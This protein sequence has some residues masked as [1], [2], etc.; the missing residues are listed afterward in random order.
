M[1]DQNSFAEFN[2]S[3]KVIEQLDQIAVG[4]KDRKN[5]GFEFEERVLFLFCSAKH[6]L[7][8][9]NNT[10]FLPSTLFQLASF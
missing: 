2:F 3:G 7:T 1:L 9:A 5:C 10:D 8:S 6:L 4:M